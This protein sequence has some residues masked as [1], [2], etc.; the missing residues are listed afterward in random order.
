M[1]KVTG[2]YTGIKGKVGNVVYSML[3]GQQIMKTRVFP[4][5]PQSTAQQANRSR[6]SDLVAVVKSVAKIFIAPAWSPTT[7][8]AQTT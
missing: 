6:L 2:V 4:F 5:N 7:S 1:A 3:N 8:G